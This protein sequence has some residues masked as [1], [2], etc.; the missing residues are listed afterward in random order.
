MTYDVLPVLALVIIG[1]FPFLPFISGKVLVPREVGALAYVYWLEQLLI[2]GGFFTFFWTRNGQTLGMLAWR[3]RLQ[4]ADGS[5]LQ[6][7]EALLRLGCVAVL[8]VPCMAGYWLVWRHWP[9]LHARKIATYASLAP[10][11]IAY[12][13]MLID[14]RRLTLP[15]RWSNTRVVLMPKKAS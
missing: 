11:A 12:L 2:V 10:F 14:P 8:F 5:T 9:D 6:W 1:T 3:L 13:W 4:R 7:R 15:D